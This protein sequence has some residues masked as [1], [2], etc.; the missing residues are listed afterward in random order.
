MN[1]GSRILLI[2]VKKPTFSALFFV[3]IH[4]FIIKLLTPVLDLSA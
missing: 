4:T 2:E 1:I 3:F